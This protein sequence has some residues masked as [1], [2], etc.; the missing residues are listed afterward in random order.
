MSEDNQAQ[1]LK[2]ILR[3]YPTGVTVVT[4]LLEGKPW[5]GTMNSFTSIS[6][7]PP[8]VAIFVMENS[9]TTSAIL[10]TGKFVV[11]ILKHDQEDAAKQ[12]ASDG[13]EDKFEG[14]KYSSND[15]G[16]PVLDESLGY[17]ECNL[18]SSQKIADHIMFVGE[19][20]NAS[21]INDLEALIYYRRGFRSF[22]Q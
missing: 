9:R 13:V 20:R 11:N 17:I 14:V 21:V 6:L 16:I 15:D 2:E 4:S 22:S 7:S 5:G 8:L 3:R 10:Q 18:H 12:F 1:E 19:V